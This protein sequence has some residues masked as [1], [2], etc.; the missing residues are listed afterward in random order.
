MIEETLFLCRNV[1]FWILVRCFFFFL[2]F[3]FVFGVKFIVCFFGFCFLGMISSSENIDIWTDV[4]V[5]GSGLAGLYYSL[6]LVENSNFDV[7]LITKR[8]LTEA[9]TRY[10]QGGIAAVVSEDD[11]VEAHVKDTL[12]AG[13]GLCHLD[14]VEHIIRTGPDRVRHLMELGVP[15]DRR[16]DGSLDLGREG[17]HSRRRILHYKDMTGQVVEDTLARLVRG[18]ERIHILENHVAVNLVL[19]DGRVTGAYVL[20]VVSGDVLSV[21]S[22]LTILATGGAGKVFLYTSNPD[23]A[24]GDGIAMA[25]RVGATVMNMEMVQFHPT[26]LYHPFAKTF[27]LTEALR[28]EGA[29]L[30]TRDGERFMPKYHEMAELAPRDVVARAIDHEMKR[31]GDDFVLLDISFKPADFI[32]SHFP[33]VYQKLLEYGYDLTKEPVPVVPAAHYTIGGVKAAVN[34]VTDVP[35]LLAIGEV[36]CTG[37]HGA[38]RLASN[39]LLE[40][41]VMAYEAAH[42][43]KEV[44]TRGIKQFAFPH[45]ESGDAVDADEAVVISHNWDELRRLMWNYVGI[46]RT[47][48]RLLRAKERIEL[49]KK[50]IN[51]YYWGFKLTRDLI[52]LRNLVEVAE[53]IVD[54]ALFRKESRG[55]HY[56]KDFP[57]KLPTPHD[58]LNQ[59]RLGLSLSAPLTD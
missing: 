9:N 29:I 53:L 30:L 7:V 41:T 12:I 24:T 14:V 13:D 31:T 17:A 10:A 19:I 38:N 44:L 39:S 43:S 18:H 34:G 59:K 26:C 5:I 23:V 21:S 11:S 8:E 49:L 40:A 50:E 27:L 32:K 16:E 35:G 42:Y 3:Y 1:L 55:A 15:F 45:W 20:D 37:L 46:V 52:E 22:K 25:Y 28:G 57:N 36:S 58:I 56:I 54:S 2:S 47:T 33:Q 6:E 4:L 48:K 51:E